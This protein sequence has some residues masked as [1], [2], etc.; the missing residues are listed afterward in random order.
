MCIRD[1]HVTEVRSGRLKWRRYRDAYRRHDDS[2]DRQ[3]REHRKCAREDHVPEGRPATPAHPGTGQSGGKDDGRFDQ[4][5][6]CHG[7]G[8]LSRRARSTWVLSSARSSS[9]HEPSASREV[10]ISVTDPPKNVST[11]WRRAVFL[12]ADVCLLYTS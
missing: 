2:R 8:F 4:E 1:R 11:N 10:I 9:R 12:A 7:F 6:E 3:K 5:R